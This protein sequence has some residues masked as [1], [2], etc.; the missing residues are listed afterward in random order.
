MNRFLALV[1]AG[2]S[3]MA[4]LNTAR[5]E[6]LPNDPALVT[7]SLENGLRY[8]VRRHGNPQ[9]RLSVWLH[10]S[11]GSLNETE[12][13]RGIAHYLEHMA[14]NGSKNF[15]PGSVVP[16]FQ[17]LGMQFGRDQNAFTSFEQTTY[18]MA[19]PDTSP[20][21]IDRAMLFLSDVGLR[22][23]LPVKEI[24]NERGIII[25]EK[26]TRASA[27]QR[28]GEYIQERIAPESTFGRRL[29]IGTEETIRSVQRP[30]FEA[31]YNTF[32][33]PSNMTVIAVGDC[34]PAQIV[35]A[36]RKHFAEGRAVPRPA[37]LDV[38][39]KPQTQTRAII[40]T[41]PEL[42]VAGV[43]IMRV[44]A[45]RPPST[46]V[47]DERRDLV[48]TIGAWAFNRRLSAALARGGKSYLGGSASANDLA[49]SLRIVSVAVNG[50]PESWRAMLREIAEDLQR[51]R[52]HGFTDR[53]VA[54]ARQALISQAE[55]A[56]KNESTLP[57]RAVL[58]RINNSVAA[59][60]PIMSA[61]QRLDLLNR[62]LPTITV[63][64]VSAAFSATFDPS[65]A[66]FM[67]QAPSGGDLPTESELIEL[68]KAAVNVK[69]EKGAEESRIEQL[70]KQAPS[71]GTI[72]ESR[73]HEASGVASAW[74]SNNIRVHYKFMDTRKDQVFVAVTVA[75]GQIQESA[76]E[77]GLTEAA[78][79]AWSRPATKGYTSTQIRDF[80]T[81]KKVRVN[82]GSGADGLSLT[83]SG[84]PAELEVGLQLAYLLLSE[85]M[86]E[87]AIFSQWKQVQ[88]QVIAA[89]KS[90]PGAVLNQVG[91]DAL[92]PPGEMRTRPLTAEQVG[93][94]KIEVA[95]N[96]LEK[97]IATMPIEIAI[98]GDIP[99]ERAMALAATYFGSLKPR[100]RIDG[101]TLDAL[102]T[103][104]RNAGPYIVEAMVETQTPQAM[105]LDGFIG[106]DQEN[107]RDARLLQMA[108]RLLSTRMVKTV[109]EERQL[110]YSISANS[111]AA[112][113]Y[114][115]FGLFAAQAPTDPVKAPMLANVLEEMYAD[116][117]RNGPSEEELTV[118]KKQMANTFAEQMKQPDF[119]VGRL[120]GMDYKSVTLDDVM[121]APAAFEAMTAAEIRD[122]F[123]RYFQ[124]ERRVR[125]VVLPVAKGS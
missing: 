111:R 105:V 34:D 56:V 69:P 50:K 6:P 19:L 61:Q 13:T 42:T 36:V 44:E 53:E 38:G 112:S 100:D 117:A 93:A 89:R 7:G 5:A 63:A 41:D 119:W 64:E 99:Q 66:T 82:G 25:E 3:M 23:E 114:P 20:E 40:A 43:T 9:G 98:V 73:T 33:V 97:I 1:L 121:G 94:L 39:T 32:Y 120:A 108:A 102:R 15:P 2:V 12:R 14:F 123:A 116:F 8:I 51:A 16:F 92:Y 67:L 115:G 62:L 46:T 17:S 30:D 110:V 95:Q 101:K 65:V 47:A 96:W 60:E 52:I 58:Q 74:L 75:G 28:V 91:A 35:A 59:G 26:R 79:L 90:Q 71:G 85:P 109:R 37:D 45:P 124:P 68:G 70:L 87:Q 4:N 31:Y 103:I 104:K 54:D 88:Q 55:Q 48:E 81:A 113:D 118:A 84:D 10:V 122:A 11:S 18:Q 125:F 49:H 78:V 107:V 27:Q 106:T 29:P 21:N 22:L 86:I 77:R 57:A 24:E 72:A 80:M 83:V 76:K